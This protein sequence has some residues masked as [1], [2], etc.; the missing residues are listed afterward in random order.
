VEAAPSGKAALLLSPLPRYHLS[1]SRDHVGDHGQTTRMM[2]RSWWRLLIG[3]RLGGALRIVRGG[4]FL[5]VGR[6]PCWFVRHRSGHAVT[7]AV[8][9]VGLRVYPFP[10]SLLPPPLCVLGET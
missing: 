4:G 9:P 10:T 7:P 2:L 6:N 8:P 1:S 5:E 3:G